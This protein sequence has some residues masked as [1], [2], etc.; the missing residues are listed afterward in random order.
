MGEKPVG[1]RSECATRMKA[2]RKLDFWWFR[3]FSTR[4]RQV[5]PRDLPAASFA[6]KEG[7][8]TNTE[9]GY[10]F[11]GSYGASGRDHAGLAY[12]LRDFSRAGYPMNYE[13]PAEILDEINRVTP[14]MEESRLTA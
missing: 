8:F 5:C 13:S 14:L 1:E 12:C 2:L 7:T 6:E 4:K 9:G 3:I 10:S 11:P